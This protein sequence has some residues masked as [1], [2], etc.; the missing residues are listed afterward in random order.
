MRLLF[1]RIIILTSIAFCISACAQVQT[2]AVTDTEQSGELFVS[3]WS[4][5]PAGD[6][7]IG[8]PAERGKVIFDSACN[9]CHSRDVRN[10]PATTSLEFKYQGQLPAALEDRTDLTAELITFYIRN[11]IAMMPFFRKTELS[12]ADV[13]LLSAYLVKQ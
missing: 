4:R 1:K 7:T 13:E 3:Q 11:G 10:A 2:E 12:D 8:T 6:K 9:V 5:Q